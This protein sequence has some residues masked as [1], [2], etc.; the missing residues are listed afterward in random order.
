MEES[1]YLIPSSPSPAMK[2]L[3]SENA[4]L[5]AE[6]LATR[7]KFTQMEKAI[8]ERQQQERMLR[9]S[10]LSVRKEVMSP[11]YYPSKL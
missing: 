10:I 4:T 8:K 7:T 1:F 11:S 6:L 9:E 3:Q 2:R 5:K